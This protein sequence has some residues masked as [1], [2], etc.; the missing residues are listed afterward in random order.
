MKKPYLFIIVLILVVTYSCGTIKPFTSFQ[1]ELSKMRKYYGTEMPVQINII[2]IDTI[3]STQ[4]NIPVK[5]EIENLTN[6]MISI[7]NLSN[8]F[9]SFPQLWKNDSV[10]PLQIKVNSHME[11][12]SLLLQTHEKTVF[13]FYCT[14]DH[15]YNLNRLPQGEYKFEIIVRPL[16][17]FPNLMFV[18]H[19]HMIYVR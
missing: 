7:N 13:P 17:N 2:M 3:D 19:P 9:Y 16:F 18:S 1:A 6:E 8:W 15:A 4:K 11:K 5:L 12:E 14:F 10:V